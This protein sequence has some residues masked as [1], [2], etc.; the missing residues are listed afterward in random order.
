MK[1]LITP[2]LPLVNFRRGVVLQVGYAVLPSHFIADSL[3]TRGVCLII[4]IYICGTGKYG[5]K[6][7]C[8]GPIK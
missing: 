3:S 2:P 8:F 4:P 5:T 7:G 1:F 6:V